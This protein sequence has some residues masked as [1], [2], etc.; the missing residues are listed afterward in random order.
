MVVL[1]LGAS[2]LL[3]NALFRVLSEGNADE[4]YGTIRKE[5]YRDFFISELSKKLF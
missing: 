2:G 1:V 4:I 5:N 3:G